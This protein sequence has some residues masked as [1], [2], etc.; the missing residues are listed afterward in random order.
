MKERIVQQPIATE[1]QEKFTDLPT[2]DTERSTF[3]MSHPWKGTMDSKYIVP[4]LLQEILPG[5]T[6]RIKSTAFMRLA[7]PLKP[8]MDSVT[9]DIHYF[10][11][12]NRLVW[13]NWQ[14]FMGERK[15][16]TDDPTTLSVP[17]L[18][19]DLALPTWTS[20]LQDYFG[21][22]MVNSGSAVVVQINALPFR[23]YQLIWN[24]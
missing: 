16:P 19:V 1:V 22:P 6:I 11:V 21:C 9:A 20:S 24:E 10:F 14:F 4:C 23:G 7:T 13:D 15:K 17:V 18:N 8:I 5:D 12:A 3:D 2:A